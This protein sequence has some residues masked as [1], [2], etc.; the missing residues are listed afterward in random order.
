M[1]KVTTVTVTF[2]DKTTELD[3]MCGAFLAHRLSSGDRTPAGR[4]SKYRI[5]VSRFVWPSTACRSL[6]AAPAPCA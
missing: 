5:V 2:G 1:P 6:A 3:I 4:A